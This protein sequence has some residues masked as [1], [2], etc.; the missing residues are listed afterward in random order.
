MKRILVLVA[1]LSI[2]ALALVAVG[3]T[4]APKGPKDGPP[5]CSDV[6][7]EV[8]PDGTCQKVCV[9][10]KGAQQGT[11]KCGCKKGCGDAAPKQ[12]AVR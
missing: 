9:C 4:K 7:E 2:L 3:Q 6:T 10:Q 1:F 11:Y 12:P 8:C 5:K